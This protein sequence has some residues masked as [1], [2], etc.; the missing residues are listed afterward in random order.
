MKRKLARWNV[1]SASLTTSCRQVPAHELGVAHE[2]V[3]DRPPQ[4]SDLGFRPSPQDM[5]KIM[6]AVLVALQEERDR[7]AERAA[8]HGAAPA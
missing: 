5:N 7:E 4:C 8:E 6:M 1:P 2:Y 3:T